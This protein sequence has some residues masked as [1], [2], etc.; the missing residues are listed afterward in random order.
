[1]LLEEQASIG[2]RELRFSV[3]DR[4]A[5]ARFVIVGDRLLSLVVAPVDAFPAE[6]ARRF[7]DSPRRL[8]AVEAGVAASA[9]GNTGP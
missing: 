5:L 9:Q 7:L 4:E 3:H 1:M 6:G 2:G 8:L